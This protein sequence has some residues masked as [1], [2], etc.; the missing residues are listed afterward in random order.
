MSDTNEPL[1]TPDELSAIQDM[2]SSGEFDEKPY[3]TDVVA[4]KFSIARN[5][6]N[7]GVSYGSLT[8]INE[9]FHRFFRTRLL[10][11]LDYN[12][13]LSVATP[14]LMKYSE[15]IRT[16]ESP[17]SINVTELDPLKGETLIVIHPQVVF[18]CLDNWYGGQ[19][20]PLIVD[21]ERN[22]TANE[23]AIIDRLCEL[24]F[25]SMKEAWSPY[26]EI[27]IS[28][29]N[30][31]INPLFANIAG[32]EESVV[33]NRFSIRLRDEEI[34]PYIDI[35]YTYQS[36]NLQRD[37]LSSRIQTQEAD[38]KWLERLHASLSEID[39]SMFVSGGMLQLSVDQLMNLKVGEVLAFNPPALAEVRVN[40]FPL[41]NA[42]VGE[43]GKK[44]AI[45]V[46]DNV[47]EEDK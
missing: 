21:G 28:L 20:R 29:V 11:E 9:R 37:M 33:V 23:N 3:N 10:T 43:S 16:V 4:E 42:E 30:R 17:A 8:Q 40:D 34:Q 2:V 5:E 13:R 25:T 35:V 38:Q 7:L 31:D 32:D 12:A 45:Q 39:F 44:V 18:S 24:M 14:Q 15:Y 22:F 41:Y 19:A 26:V 46:L 47:L 27:D 1:L 36:L 6:E